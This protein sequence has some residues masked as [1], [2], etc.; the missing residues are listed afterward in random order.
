V[1]SVD[2]TIVILGGGQTKSWGIHAEPNA[3]HASNNIAR[4]TPRDRVLS[5]RHAH[6]VQVHNT[7]ARSFGYGRLGRAA[8]TIGVWDRAVRSPVDHRSRDTSSDARSPI[9]AV[10][11]LSPERR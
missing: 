3:A 4:E 5:R 9:Q 11:V 1:G 7:V 6:V 2:A 10:Q 8:Q